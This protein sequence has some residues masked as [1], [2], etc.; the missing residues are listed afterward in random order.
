MSTLYTGV[1]AGL[2]T[3]VQITVPADGDA[4]NAATFDVGMQKLA[5]YAEAFRT[6]VRSGAIIE[7]GWLGAQ[8]GTFAA[9]NSLVTLAPTGTGLLVAT[10][11]SDVT[12]S[13]STFKLTANVSGT[14]R[15]WLSRLMSNSTGNAV[16]ASFQKNGGTAINSPAEFS[17]AQ[18]ASATSPMIV[19]AYVTLAAT[20]FVQVA[21]Y[22]TIGQTY[23][24][25][26]PL[27]F[28]GLERIA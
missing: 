22:G 3:A 23:S 5:D 25:A 13:P 26:G 24:I 16:N 2:T 7:W 10:M 14:Y 18:L 17:I 9:S 28:F 12:A 8:A 27:Q 21:F 11:G 6:R 4:D 20:D 1:A 15:V 19:D